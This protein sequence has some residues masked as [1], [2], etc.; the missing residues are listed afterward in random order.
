MLDHLLERSTG[1]QRSRLK[2]KLQNPNLAPFLLEVAERYMNDPDYDPKH[3]VDL[4][5]RFR[6]AADSRGRI[7]GHNWGL[8]HNWARALIAGDE[9]TL[10]GQQETVQRVVGEVRQAMA[11]TDGGDADS[12][13]TTR[14]NPTTFAI[15]AAGIGLL[16]WLASRRDEE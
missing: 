6:A 14:F 12:T 3:A 13:S 4:R 2:A 16:A 10:G 15:G 1:A 9:L 11:E 5:E 8:L 7:D